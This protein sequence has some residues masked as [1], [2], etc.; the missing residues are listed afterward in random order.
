MERLNNYPADAG[1][2]YIFDQKNGIYEKTRIESLNE[3]YLLFTGAFPFGGEKRVSQESLSYMDGLFEKSDFICAPFVTAEQPVSSGPLQKSSALKE[4]LET[5][6]RAGYSLLYTTEAN[7][8]DS[9]ADHFA[10][11]NFILDR[12]HAEYIIELNHIRIAFVRRIGF[13]RER[14]E[15]LRKKGVDF[16]IVLCSRFKNKVRERA[17]ELANAGADLIAMTCRTVKPYHTVTADDGRKVPYIGG[18]GSLFS[19]EADAGSAAVRIRLL[20]DA[21]GKVTFQARYI[22]VQQRENFKKLDMAVVPAHKAFN[23]GFM[24]RKMRAARADIAEMIGSGIRRDSTLSVIRNKSGFKPQLSIREICDILGLDVS[25]YDG[26]YPV[27][28]KVH[29]III[30]KTELDKN[31]VA[32]IQNG[33]SSRKINFTA[34]EAAKAQAVLAITAK[35]VEGLPC[36]VVDDPTAAYIKLATHIR[37]QYHPLTIGITGTIGKSTTTDMI[38]TVMKYGFKTLDVRGNY[39][40][41]KGIG[42]CIQKLDDTFDAYVQEVHGGQTDAASINS[43]ILQPDLCV[44]TYVGAAHLSQVRG[45]TVYDVLREKL[46]I[47]DGLREGGTLFINN[48]NEY[49]REVT[50]EVNT[51]RYAANN[52]DADYYAENIVDYSDQIT[53]TIVCDEGRFDALLNCGGTYNVANA[54]CAFAVG[55]AAGIAPEKIIAGLARYRTEGYRQ[56][57]IRRNGYIMTLDCDST[58]PD[59]MRSALNSF[60]LTKTGTNGRYIAVLGDTAMLGAQKESWHRQYGQWIG[61]LGYDAIITLGPGSL[62]TCE[63]AAAKG[64]EVYGYLDRSEFESKIKEFLKPGDH[65]LFK[66]SPKGGADLIPTIE[67]IFGRIR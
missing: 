36:F 22:P 38:K 48:D 32:V 14:S 6:F 62:F 65:V 19:E 58:T 30:R 11:G 53:F 61:D 10:P 64:V 5:A 12:Q 37:E 44:V 47:T 16:V 2:E 56:N 63:E 15:A 18:L 54:V 51:I 42:L 24:D 20:R 35:P 8:G 55:R 28:E 9:V 49:L 50:P 31:C 3:V 23:G 52:K 33:G 46:R 7:A 34:E 26:A 39:N 25:Q 59:S 57:V 43:K 67:H 21:S 1:A 17:Q 13:T 27:D 40:T 4:D 60:A 29:S 41:Y 45:G 66:S